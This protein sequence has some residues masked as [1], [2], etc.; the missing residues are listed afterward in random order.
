MALNIETEQM[1]T[2]RTAISINSE[3]YRY[4]QEL[5]RLRK[6][7]SFSR[8]VQDLIREEH[9]RRFGI[10]TEG[11]QPVVREAVKHAE[12]KMRKSAGGSVA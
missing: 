8:L 6:F 4:A 2:V 1:E 12:K 7:E 5:Q 11:I 10:V 3:L 9:E